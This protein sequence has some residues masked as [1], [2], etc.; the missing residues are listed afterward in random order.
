MPSLRAS[1]PTLICSTALPWQFSQSDRLSMTQASLQD[2]RFHAALAFPAPQDCIHRIG[3]IG[4]DNPSHHRDFPGHQPHLVRVA[5]AR[6][7]RSE[8]L[9]GSLKVERLHGQGFKTRRQAMDEVVA[10]MLWYK[11]RPDCTRRW[12]TSAHCSSKKTG[13]PINH[14]RPARSPAVGYGFQGQDQTTD[15]T[16]TPAGR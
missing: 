16:F 3:S 15:A 4:Q 9:F 8:T 11:Q 7:I 2:R 13:S 6:S 12:P 5:S 10:W 14:G 1:P